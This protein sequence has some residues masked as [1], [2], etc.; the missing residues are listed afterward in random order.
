MGEGERGGMEHDWS[1]SLVRV[2]ILFVMSAVALVAASQGAAAQPNVEVVVDGEAVSDGGNVT[3]GETAEINVT[4]TSSTNLSYVRIRAGDETTSE[5]EDSRRFTYDH[6]PSIDLGPTT[7]AV[8]AGD[9]DGSESTTTIT[10]YRPATNRRQLAERLRDIR[11]TVDN[12]KSENER[13]R[14]ERQNLTERRDRLD[15][16]L[17]NTSAGPDGGGGGMPGFGAVVAVVAA[18]LG[19][20]VARRT[21]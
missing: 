10:L 1:R 14:Q 13:L 12:L 20:G 3:V 11:R 5:G 18:I 9:A 17:N 8:E 6:A 4:V 21:R 19:L 7:Y 15:R 2:G 16:R